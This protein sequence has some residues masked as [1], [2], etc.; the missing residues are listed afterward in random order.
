MVNLDALEQMRRQMGL[1]YPSRDG[2]CIAA[3]ERVTQALGDGATTVEV[4]SYAEFMG[5]EVL[6]AVHMVSLLDGQVI[7]FTASQFDSSLPPVIVMPVEEYRA[8]MQ[9]TLH[10]TRVTIAEG[11]T[12]EGSTHTAAW[13][14]FMGRMNIYR[15]LHQ[16]VDDGQYER[17]GHEPPISDRA[18]SSRMAW[19]ASGKAWPIAYLDE[20][21]TGPVYEALQKIL[22]DA[23]FPS[24][25]TLARDT[26]DVFGDGRPLPPIINGS[27]DDG[28]CTDE[29]NRAV[30][31]VPLEDVVGVGDLGED[32]FFVRTHRIEI[33]SPGGRR[34]SSLAKEAW[35]ITDPEIYIT[36]KGAEIT[37]SDGPYGGAAAYTKDGT[38]VG[39]LGWYRDER[40]MEKYG[41]IMHV[42]VLKRWQRQGIATAM[43]NWAKKYV[44]SLRHS[45]SL[46]DDGKA[47]SKTVAHTAGTKMAWG[48]DAAFTISSNTPMTAAKWVRWLQPESNSAWVK[49]DGSLLAVYVHDNAGPVEGLLA[50]GW[51][52]LS[53]EPEVSAFIQSDV[54]L[55]DGQVDALRLVVMQSKVSRIE[56]ASGLGHRFSIAEFPVL[57]PSDVARLLRTEL[58]RPAKK[59]AHTASAPSVQDSIERYLDLIPPSDATLLRARMPRVVEGATGGPSFAWY[60]PTAHT[61]NFTTGPVDDGL[62]FHEMTHAL[63]WAA[64]NISGTSAYSKGLVPRG[65]GKGW[66]MPSTHRNAHSIAAEVF[67]DAYMA[68][69]FPGREGVAFDQMRQSHPDRYEG[70]LEIARNVSLA[71][72]TLRSQGGTH[73]ASGDRIVLDGPNGERFF[74]TPSP[75]R[76]GVLAWLDGEA[77]ETPDRS[78]GNLSWFPRDGEI[79]AVRVDPE[80]RRMGIARAMLDLARQIDP[81]VHHS[82][83]LSADGEAWSKA[84]AHKTAKTSLYWRVHPKA[85]PFTAEDA[86]STTFTGERTDRGYSCFANPWHLLT[87][88]DAQGM[89]VDAG[90]PTNEILAFTGER[91]GTG[92]DGEDLV[93]PD[94][95]IVQHMTLDDLEHECS[96]LPLP[97]KPE[98]AG[99]TGYRSWDEFKRMVLPE[100]PEGALA[101]RIRAHGARATATSLYRGIPADIPVDD[102]VRKGLREAL[103]DAVRAADARYGTGVHW[104]ASEEVA[105]RFARTSGVSGGYGDQGALWI[106]P[107]GGRLL[108]RVPVVLT[109]RPRASDIIDD[110]DKARGAMYLVM[111][112]T[113]EDEVPISYGAP[114]VIDSAQVGVPDDVDFLARQINRFN[115]TGTVEEHIIDWH[116]GSVPLPITVRA[117][118]RMSAPEFVRASG[119]YTSNCW[120]YPDGHVLAVEEHAYLDYVQAFEG[121]LVRVALDKGQ[122]VNIE[123][124]LPLTDAQITAVRVMY[125]Q[126]KCSRIYSEAAFSQHRYDNRLNWTDRR[127]EG[128]ISGVDPW[129]ARLNQFL[130]ET[131]TPTIH[132]SVRTTAVAYDPTMHAYRGVDLGLSAA[133]GEPILE[134]IA[135]GKTNVAHRLLIDAMAERALNKPHWWSIGTQEPDEAGRWWTTRR[136]DAVE[137]AFSD[138]QEWITI[139]VVLTAKFDEKDWPDAPMDNQGVTVWHLDPGHLIT[140]VDF[141]ATLPNARAA[142]EL[143]D[144][145]RGIT[146]KGN[147]DEPGVNWEGD[148][149]RLNIPPMRTTAAQTSRR[150]AMPVPYKY[151]PL[152]ADTRIVVPDFPEWDDRVEGDCGPV[153]VA[154]LAGISYAEAVAECTKA[155]FNGGMTF[156][157]AAKVLKRYRQCGNATRYAVGWED[158]GT[159]VDN[160]LRKWLL[161]RPSYTGLVHVVS[162]TALEGHLMAVISGWVFNGDTS[163]DDWQVDGSLK[164]NDWQKLKRSAVYFT[165]D[166]VRAI[167]REA[168]SETVLFHGTRLSR[169]AGIE[170]DGLH[171]PEGV[172]PW[173]WYMLTTS[174]SQAERYSMPVPGDP[175]AVIEYRLSPEQVE[176]YLGR[177]TPHDVYGFSAQAYG[178]ARPPLPGSLIHKVHVGKQV[179]AVVRTGVALGDLS[180]VIEDFLV[181]NPASR[182]RDSWSMG[183]DMGLIEDFIGAA[184]TRGVSAVLMDCLGVRVSE[185]AFDMTQANVVAV[186][187]FTVVDFHAG[188]FWP[189]APVPLVEPIEQYR[190][191]WKVWGSGHTASAQ[192][193]LEHFTQDLGERKP[194]HFV[195]AVSPSGEIMGTLNWYGTTGMVASIDVEPQ[196]RRQGI[197]TAM[198]EHAQQFSP[199]PKH[200][201]DRTDDGDAWARS[202]GGPLPRRV[203]GATDTAADNLAMARMIQSLWGS[204]ALSYP[205]G[206]SPRYVYR[207]MSD[208]EYVQAR[209]RG[210]FQSD[211]R[212]D[213]R[214]SHVDGYDFPN[215]GTVA[216]GEVAAGYLPDGRGRIVR[217]DVRP[218]DGWAPLEDAWMDGMPEFA[219]ANR[220]P[221]DR[222]SVSPVIYRRQPPREF[223]SGDVPSVRGPS[224]YGWDSISRTSGLDFRVRGQIP[225]EY[226][227][228]A[229]PMSVKFLKTLAVHTRIHEDLGPLVEPIE[230]LTIF[231]NPWQGRAN[232][233]D[234]NHRLAR[235]VKQRM[236]TLPVVIRVEPDLVF[237]RDPM[238]SERLS[239]TD[240][241]VKVGDAVR[242]SDVRWTGKTQALASI[243]G[244]RLWWRVHPAHREFL[245]E[246]ATSTPIDNWHNERPVQGFSAVGNPWH[247][248]TYCAN[249]GWL[250]D[251]GP[252]KAWNDDVIAFTGTMQDGKWNAGGWQADG[253]RDK[254]GA[255]GEPLVIPDM[256][257]V[258]RFSWAEFERELMDTPFPSG[259]SMGHAYEGDAVIRSGRGDWTRYANDLLDGKRHGMWS[260]GDRAS[261]VANFVIEKWLGKSVLM[262]AAHHPSNARTSALSRF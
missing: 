150:I 241:S 27:I 173:T 156:P 40:D 166:E 7:D 233:G 111:P 249:M 92:N 53:V 250:S 128:G 102:I 89:Y 207:S 114:V 138:S 225:A 154:A 113:D 186:C 70:L 74:I 137:Y 81:R 30:F 232:L 97:D 19:R 50:D 222:A 197:S 61:L 161:A 16:L 260:D 103:L 23:G 255:D 259:P 135:E 118:A 178:V 134:A 28:W 112:D 211:Q 8:L 179:D 189:G 79:I 106:R 174:Q 5:T 239:M 85:R 243:G 2:D 208:G 195:Q 133:L 33:E 104:S 10:A 91:V 136:A 49:P 132:T 122:E 213:R 240:T 228:L 22:R 96:N 86:T 182:V 68:A 107:V 95:R 199:K 76:G 257:V 183:I 244:S 67:V 25:L 158:D 42:D 83:R 252:S 262:A 162:T 140:I 245:P 39:H 142:R 80:Y 35:Y 254:M 38:Q 43:F 88:L 75:V 163:Y 126:G 217:F 171:P 129:L 187:G 229:E 90:Q 29:P 110:A 51:V 143:L 71:A 73:T 26:L 251:S 196:Y 203:Q 215:Y 116:W 200:S 24:R 258:Q 20:C 184:N 108:L 214:N 1:S 223:Y 190:K 78:I 210:Y 153:A 164:V 238:V 69:H 117:S 235:A 256:G 226:H 177:A 124:H 152:D 66:H 94:M 172:N 159:L 202:V 15:P 227:H 198:W 181:R 219:T 121:G 56:V 176:Q 52:R 246:A 148:S 119:D 36:P 204:E 99:R 105:R 84:V 155:G 87:Y 41:E 237:D 231:W 46:T 21:S 216:S 65:W 191:R 141:N 45:H 47:W 115:R 206:K 34:T 32:E 101:D 236:S 63:D 192:Y 130:I 144:A 13:M 212:S 201:A 194:R 12:T 44:P 247:L 209:S 169:V 77:T 157:E 123:A 175:T 60:D 6:G 151:A 234:G 149:V 248:W 185:S 261:R 218:E 139:P 48:E 205:G 193:T 180:K 253:K 55:T 98:G 160:T 37:I 221:L 72:Q 100:W 93:I 168:L 224:A 17:T 188:K 125:A 109:G 146:S 147:F 59:T 64:G 165:E 54:V 18:V 58:P 9:Q 127:Y 167:G 31:T 170:R 242:P 14:D 11:F 82:E 131:Q 230:P 62:V 3:S 220:I 4:I 57:G 145:W 120:L